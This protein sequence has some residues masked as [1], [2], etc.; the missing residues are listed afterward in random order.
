MFKARSGLLWGAVN[1]RWLSEI[2][3][4]VLQISRWLLRNTRWLFL[5][6]RHVIKYQILPLIVRFLKF[7]FILGWDFWGN[8]SIYFVSLRP[9][10][11]RMDEL[12]H[13]TNYFTKSSRVPRTHGTREKVDNKC[14]KSVKSVHVQNYKK[15][16]NYKIFS[17]KILV[18]YKKVVPLQAISTKSPANMGCTSAK[19]KLSALSLHHL[20]NK[21]VGGI[22]Q[23][24]RA[25]DS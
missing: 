24:V 6:K 15:T 19:S 7:R 3:R 16:L 25:H 11:R 14:V 4:W 17:P 10:Q 18:V 21:N 8:V 9:N 1:R 5:E 22:A 23:L 2:S 13:L 12:T 20:C